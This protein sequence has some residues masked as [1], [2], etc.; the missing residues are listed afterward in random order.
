[1]QYWF[2]SNLH[3][4]NVSRLVHF[5]PEL[6]VKILPIKPYIGKIQI[7][8]LNSKSHLKICIDAVEWDFGDREGLQTV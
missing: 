4:W 6:V 1:M 3:D 8:F 5:D 2:C 7:K